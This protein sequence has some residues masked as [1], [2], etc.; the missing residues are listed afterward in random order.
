MIACA[1]S[2]DQIGMVGPLSNTASWQ[3]VPETFSS[4]GDWAENRLPPGMNAV[5]MGNRIAQYSARLY[6]RLPIL[7]GF[8]LLINQA[9]I[10]QIGYFDEETYG[11]GYGEENDYCLRAQQAGWQ[12]AVADDAYVYHAQSKSYS[13]RRRLELVE[14]SDRALV[15]KYGPQVMSNSAQRCRDDRVMNGIRARAQV[16]SQREELREKGGQLWEGQRILIILPIADPGG[17][18]NVV[19]Q[20]SEAMQCM[21]VDVHIAN[22]L[23]HRSSFERWYPDLKLPTFFIH[24]PGL[25]RTLLSKYDA[26]LATVF[27]SV[28]WMDVGMYTGGRF[29]RGYYIQDFEPDFFSDD[30]SNYKSA[31]ESYTRFSDL[32]RMTKT[33][34]NRD[35]VKKRIGVDCSVV[36]PSVDIDLFRPRR[37]IDPDWPQ[38][39]L[40][41]AAMVRPNTPRRQ[42]ELTLRVLKEITNQHR[43]AVEIILFGCQA[44]DPDF[45]KLQTDFPWR[46]AGILTRRQ[47]AFLMNEID[48]FVDF[49]AFQAMGLT[50]MEAMASGAAVIVPQYGGAGSFAR[51]EENS[52]VVDTESPEACLSVL[53]RLLSNEQLRNHIQRQGM[54]DVCQYFPERAAL[55]ILTTLFSNQLSA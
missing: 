18:G 40:R 26:L 15:T 17:G 4:D 46:S 3:S 10:Q 39:P 30:S 8:C 32:V 36:G 12:I 33:D 34:W 21:G 24:E 1:E 38:R 20:E 25:S 51:D 31:W 35:M 11:D 41:I 45:H 14:R 48:I 5:D 27:H 6:P 37:R 55:N 2:D 7:N 52:L 28:N 49:S 53:N 22:L 16:M 54:W 9:L 50:A 23:I 13:H 44:E 47:L 42:P 29:V 43:G 19:I